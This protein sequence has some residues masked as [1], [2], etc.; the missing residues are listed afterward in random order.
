MP[1]KRTTR[2]RGRA[3][4]ADDSDDEDIERAA[5]TDSD[6]SHESASDTDSDSDS[7]PVS[8]HLT[9]N[10]SHSP[11]ADEKPAPFF[12]ATPA[13]W[14]DMVD[15]A[16]GL[17]VIT[18]G[19]LDAHA[20]RK[21]RMAEQEPEPEPESDDEEDEQPVASSSRHS[22][23]PPAPFVRRPQSSQ[24]ARQAYQHRLE[25][26]PSFVPVVG[27]FWGHDDRLLDKDL[28]SLS[29]WWRGRWQ[30]RGGRGVFPPRGRGRG[31]F[32]GPPGQHAAQEELAP[33]SPVDR[34]W[35][36]DGFEEMRRREDT[37]AR[38]PVRGGAPLSSLR[39][40]PPLRAIG[41]LRGRGGP[42]ANRQPGRIWY[43]MKPDHMWTKQ[44]DAFLYFDPAL[45]PRP[46]QPPGVRV[47]LPGQASAIVRAIPRVHRARVAQK[48]AVAAP[49]FDYV[50]RLP[51]RRGKGRATAT[52]AQEEAEVDSAFTVKL[53]APL[54][55]SHP[56]APHTHATPDPA[57]AHPLQPD[58]DGWVQPTAAA[59]ALAAAASPPSAPAPVLPLSLPP[60]PQV[61]L[62]P[63]AHA[64]PP[65]FFPFAPPPGFGFPPGP[66]FAPAPVLPS[67]AGGFSPQHQAHASFSATPP[68]PPGFSTHTPPPGFGTPP[69]GFGTPPPGFSGLPMQ[70]PPGVGIDGRGMPFEIASGRPVVLQAPPQPV[71]VWMGHH[72]QQHSMH[73]GH[74]HSMSLGAG[75]GM[76]GGGG[77]LFAFARPARVRVEIRAPNG[78]PAAPNG[79]NGNASANGSVNG[80]AKSP[81]SP[82]AA[83]GPLSPL[84]PL[85]RELG[86]PQHG[87]GLGHAH[88]K[89]KQLRTGAAAFVPGHT[90]APSLAL[91]VHAPAP[92]DH[93]FG[94]GY[95]AGGG[96]SGYD[97]PVGGGGGYGGGATYYYPYYGAPTPGPGDG[98][99]YYQ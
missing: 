37:R 67:F 56:H 90:P 58:A 76:G 28:R 29:G 41:T 91:P 88:Q 81:T 42:P 60:A 40:T 47:R 75:Q 25:S 80:H 13:A 19:E 62:H 93:Y 89:S 21:V 94:N 71:P 74:G 5:Q 66:A 92:Q 78:N 61:Q 50:V 11:D 7:E 14:S 26:D 95:E 46:G 16:A 31:A 39:G 57:S 97:S 45:K 15:D 73:M 34:T 4:H 36:H 79:T 85:S 55:S 49:E 86:S 43:T 65:A 30:G 8:R 6:V 23:A 96:G 72:P 22:P 32:S 10:T 27:E 20:I 48:P 38:P 84:S 17:P 52:T 1:S 24:S 9:P 2:R 98:A 35:T 63:N 69:P 33:D 70:L 68:P 54:H 44:H 59:V 87:N 77:E 53:P 12:S 82:P 18:F 3:P 99:V 64:Q 51:P 83:V